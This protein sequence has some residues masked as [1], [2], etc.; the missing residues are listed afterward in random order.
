MQ[1]IRI[2]TSQN[3]DIDYEIAGL[4]ERIVARLIDLAIFF[5]VAFAFFITYKIINPPG[6]SKVFAITMVVI[7]FTLYVFYDIV[8]EIFMNGQSIGKRTMN[9]KVISLDGGQASVGQYLLRWLFRIV[10]FMLTSGVCALISAA[11]SEK[12]QR[13]GDMVAGTTLIKTVARTQID[14]V[15]FTPYR[16]DYIPVFSEVTRL[17]DKDIILVH[18]VLS[19][20]IKSGNSVILYNTAIK[21]KQLLGITT[22]MDDM[23]F[24][25][26]LVRDYNH[27]AAATDA[28]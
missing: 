14:A 18:E 5:L 17:N 3:I 20:Y 9:I 10:D 15:A 1:T 26:T 6:G 12:S 2:T 24:L 19:S 21:L 28:V 25:Q 8:C 4:G 27:I 23:M 11:V 16:E 7:F 13:V 22:Q